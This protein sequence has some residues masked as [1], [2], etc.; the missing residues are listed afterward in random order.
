MTKDVNPNLFQAL[1]DLRD[2]PIESIIKHW[3]IPGMRWGRR[4]GAS[5]SGRPSDSRRKERRKTSYEYDKARDLSKRNYKS[6]SNRQLKQLNERMYLERQMRE[7]KRTNISGGR[8]FAQDLLASSA[9]Q[10]ASI[11]VNKYATKGLDAYFE[12]RLAGG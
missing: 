7:L 8:K 2:M 9:K 6:L 5:D 4:K 10:T 1:E 3:G 12:A 11:Y